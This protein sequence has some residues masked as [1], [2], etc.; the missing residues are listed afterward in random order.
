MFAVGAGAGVGVGAVE[1]CVVPD[2]VTS[3]MLA[4]RRPAA[5]A[6]ANAL[7]RFKPTS[8]GMT[9][10]VS[11]SSSSS[12]EALRSTLTFGVSIPVA[13]GGGV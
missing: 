6:R 1:G 3:S 5:E 4:T 9:Y 11:G 10:A 8:E 7:L 13:L 2:G 12:A